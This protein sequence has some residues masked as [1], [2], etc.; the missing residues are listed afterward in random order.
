MTLN[1][2]AYRP[3]VAVVG[4]LNYARLVGL[5]KCHGDG[6]MVLELVPVKGEVI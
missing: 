5:S 4:V 3:G 6:R 1:H 2:P